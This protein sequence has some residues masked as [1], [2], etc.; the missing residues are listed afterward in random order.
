MT[1]LRGPDPYALAEERLATVPTELAVSDRDAEC[2]Q[3]LHESIP[4]FNY[5]ALYRTG[6]AAL[7]LA[8]WVGSA[9]P[10]SYLRRPRSEQTSV[11]ND[12][13]TDPNPPFWAGSTRAEV[14]L[15]FVTSAGQAALLVA[16]DHR[17]AF[18]PADLALLRLVVHTLQGCER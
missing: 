10:P 17:G 9:P 5:V 18:G 8:T 15:P 4:T 6:N 14:L 11:R 16:S 12:L 13:A 3:I 1:T 2:C 7:D